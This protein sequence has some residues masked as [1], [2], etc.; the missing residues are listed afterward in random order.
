MFDHDNM[1]DLDAPEP[2]V[3]ISPM[4]NKKRQNLNKNALY[5]SHLPSKSPIGGPNT[6]GM[7]S[8]HTS[9][10]FSRTPGGNLNP[11]A[12]KQFHASTENLVGFT[13]AASE[14]SFDKS[15]P[16]GLG[17]LTRRD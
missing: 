2:L 3:T 17:K 6:K 9:Q 11:P 14:V 16:S 5:G 4:T 15:S 7:G 13:A 12:Q 10:N 8:V 1:L